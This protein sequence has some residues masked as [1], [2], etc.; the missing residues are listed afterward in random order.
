[1]NKESYTL[2]SPEENIY[3]F[4]SKGVNGTII[5]A[6]IFN[7][8]EPNVYNMALMDYNIEKEEFSD[9]SS[10][11]NG[12]IAKVMATVAEII[13]AYLQQ[14]QKHI[15]YFEGNTSAKN[16]L[17]NRIIKNNYDFFTEFYEIRGK[18]NIEGETQEIYSPQNQYYG[19]YIYKKR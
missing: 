19:F 11:N 13:H 1:M 17:Y 6:V 8:Y 4:E 5:K 18:I 7:E 3:Y 14:H 10:S 2:F 15:V 16:K 9:T 12:D